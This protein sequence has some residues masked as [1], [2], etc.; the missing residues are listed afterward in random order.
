MIGENEMKEIQ[1]QVFGGH[2][3]LS[4][5]VCP[6]CSPIARLAA[7][8]IDLNAKLQKISEVHDVPTIHANRIKP[9]IL[10]VGGDTALI[11]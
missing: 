2:P 3:Q 6:A 7:R 4:L 10:S 11:L 8:Q 1:E 5:H 9:P